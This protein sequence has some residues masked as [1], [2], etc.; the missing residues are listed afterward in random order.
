MNQPL[1]RKCIGVISG[2]I[3]RTLGALV[4]S[5]KSRA[6][7]AR[8]MAHRSVPSRIDEQTACSW[9]SFSHAFS[10]AVLITILFAGFAT[11]FG[12]RLTSAMLAGY[13]LV[14]AEPA[15]RKLRTELWK[16]R[17]DAAT[18]Q[19]A[20]GVENAK[21]FARNAEEVEENLGQLR[22]DFSSDPSGQVLYDQ[23]ALS[24]DQT[25]S[26]AKANM[27]ATA[28]QAGALNT[29]RQN[30]VSASG[31]LQPAAVEAYAVRNRPTLARRVDAA[32]RIE[33]NIREMCRLT[34]Q[35]AATQAASAEATPEQNA[36]SA[37]V[38]EYIS[39]IHQLGHSFRTLIFAQNETMAGNWELC[40]RQ[41][42]TA[43]EETIR[44]NGERRELS[45][46]LIL[47][48]E[49]TDQFIAAQ[50]EPYRLTRLGENAQAVRHTLAWLG[51]LFV[52]WVSTLLC[53]I[54]LRHQWPFSYRQ[55]R[56]A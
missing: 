36:A 35:L 1:L 43:S 37:K 21:H 13:R 9:P 40:W 32:N 11:Y 15:L 39:C 49:T 51:A 54:Y 10:T 14:S 3:V 4:S 34:V 12:V 28:L 26:L 41:A 18:Y 33:A 30:T 56:A 2:A 50:L 22:I 48:L 5:Q 27:H 20:G 8:V 47:A 44:L 6:A 45:H 16:N 25:N 24:W 46:R 7:S 38:R 29:L 42:A 52:I 53:T 23:F 17:R 31:F 19:L 55:L